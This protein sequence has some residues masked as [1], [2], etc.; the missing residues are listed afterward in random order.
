MAKTN[1]KQQ[2][3][4]LDEDREKLWIQFFDS[5]ENLSIRSSWY[6]SKCYNGLYR[7]LRSNLGLLQKFLGVLKVVSND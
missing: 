2:V 4:L 1:A 6:I 7:N 5:I 3:L